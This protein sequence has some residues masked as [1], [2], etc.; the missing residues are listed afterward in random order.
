[1]MVFSWGGGDKAKLEAEI[2]KSKS[3]RLG[4]KKIRRTKNVDG[5]T[6]YI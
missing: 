6:A 4:K 2:Q 1:M 3:D 5:G